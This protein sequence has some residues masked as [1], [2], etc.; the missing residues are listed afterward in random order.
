VDKFIGDA[1]MAVWGA[2]LPVPDHAA[3]ACLAAVEMRR[4]V[5]SRRADWA[6]RYGLDVHVRAGV[7]TCLAVAGNVGS[8]RKANFTVFGDGVNLASRLEGANKAYG[9]SVLAGDAT[10]AAAGA[11]LAFRSIDLLRVKGKREGVPVHELWDRSA[12]L[13]AGDRDWLAGWESAV[14][15]YRSRRFAEA[16]ERF[17]ALAAA[18]PGDGV[19]RLYLDRC[20]GLLAAPPPPGWDGTF[21]LHEK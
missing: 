13:P 3:R 20:A 12:A 16:R 1:V 6:R 18:R 11:A 9:T 19:A 4:A 21:E 15:D 10:R 5:E 8:R 14:A 2:P 7:N 17:A